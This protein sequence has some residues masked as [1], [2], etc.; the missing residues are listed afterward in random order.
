L[1][2]GYWWHKQEREWRAKL[3]PPAFLVLTFALATESKLQSLFGRNVTV[4]DWHG[5]VMKLTM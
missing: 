1:Y 3:K 2:A 5:T 4:N